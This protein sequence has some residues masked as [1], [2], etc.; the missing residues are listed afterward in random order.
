MSRREVPK[1]YE[2]SVRAFRIRKRAELREAARALAACR[3]GD[4]YMPIGTALACS[5]DEIEWAIRQCSQKN[6]GK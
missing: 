6:W 4:L 1:R 3:V 2:K 5:S